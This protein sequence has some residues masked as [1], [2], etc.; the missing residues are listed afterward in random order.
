MNASLKWLNEELQ[1][2]LQVANILSIRWWSHMGFDELKKTGWHAC[3]G[4]AQMELLEIREQNY[5]KEC[6]ITYKDVADK[7]SN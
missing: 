7:A 5:S 3:V 6:K 1:S 4:R 2:E